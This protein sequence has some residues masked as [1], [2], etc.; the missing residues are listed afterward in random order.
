[1]GK[2]EEKNYFPVMAICSGMQAINDFRLALGLFFLINFNILLFFRIYTNSGYELALLLGIYLFFYA[3]FTKYYL[4][5]QLEPAFGEIIF[6]SVFITILDL[7]IITAFIFFTG[8]AESPYALLYLLSLISIPLTFPY[9]LKSLFIWAFAA[10]AAYLF[11]LFFTYS[12]LILVLNGY[13]PNIERS[14][15]VIRHLQIVNGIGVPAIIFILAAAAYFF[16]SN[17]GRISDY[18]TRKGKISHG[19][20]AAGPKARHAVAHHRPRHHS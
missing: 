19:T 14:P 4:A 5:S 13:S 20:K 3:F 12:R 18:F 15:D 7:G 17:I 10:S 11:M 8:A 2:T 9:Y 6:L 1:M 16:F